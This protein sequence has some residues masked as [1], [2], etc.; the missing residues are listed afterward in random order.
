[1]KERLVFFFVF[2]TRSSVFMCPAPIYQLVIA[3]ISQEQI[4][5]NILKSCCQLRKH[6]SRIQ[7]PI[8][9]GFQKYAVIVEDN[10]RSFILLKRL[11]KLHM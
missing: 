7:L 3:G 10:A 9:K 4:G 5:P 1:M 6:C 11:K 2:S 8:I